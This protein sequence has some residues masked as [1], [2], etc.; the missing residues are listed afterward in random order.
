MT[1]NTRVTNICAYGLEKS[2]EEGPDR[3]AGLRNENPNSVLSFTENLNYKDILGKLYKIS[4]N[5]I[6]C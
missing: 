2:R 1:C 4:L 5:D 6:Y 3:S